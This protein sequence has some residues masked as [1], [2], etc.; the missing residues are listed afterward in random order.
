MMKIIC[1]PSKCTG[2]MACVNVCAHHAVKIKTDE[3]GFDRPYIDSNLCVDCGLCSKTCPIN[4]HPKVNETKDV[5]SGWSA[6]DKVRINSSSGGAFTEIARPILEKGGVV[7]GCAL[8]GKLQAEH[9]YVETF[10]ELETKLRGS[11]Y[12]QSRIGNSYSKAKDF[13]RQG[14]K[15]LFSGTPCQIAGLKNYLRREYENLI[16]VDL[17][18]HGVPSPMLFEDYK[19]FMQKHEKM[20]LTNVSFRCKKSSWIFYNMTLKGHVEKGSALKTYIGRYYED[21]YIRGSLRDY[22]LRPSCHQCKFTSIQRCSDFTI[23]DW[24][25]Y[26]KVSE[27]DR[28]FRKKGVSLILANTDKAVAMV[29]FLNMVLRKRTIDEAKKT[30]CSLS[31]AFAMPVIRTDFWKDYYSMSFN[32]LVSKYM[33]PEKV[34]WQ[35]KIMEHYPN[36]DKL[37]L[38]IRILE[39]PQ[40]VINK[41]FKVLG[42]NIKI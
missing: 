30:N 42:L 15:V 38:L 3:E 35:T 31:K 8:N 16:T 17:I 21:P 19:E 1:E 32:D 4:Q 12:V 41:L 13:L 22:F 14:R 26:S 6:D 37:I 10:E 29:P 33:M 34:R 23:A 9:I 7:F 20:K 5:Y 24:W 27:S 28:D 40:R 25:G 11:K 2:C 39:L 18:C 36:T